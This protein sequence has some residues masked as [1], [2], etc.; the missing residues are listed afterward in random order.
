VYVR[1]ILIRHAD[2][3]ER[4]PSRWP[5]DTQ[6]PITEK[7][8]RRHRQVAKRLKRRGLVPTLL[9]TSPWLR[10]WQTAEITAHYTGGTAPLAAAA[11]AASPSLDQLEQAVGRPAPDAVVALVGHEPWLGELASLLLAGE[12]HRMG[13]DLPKS[14]VLGVECESLSPGSAVLQFLWRPKSE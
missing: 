4:D 13:T 2:A 1:L 7:G 9:L 10:A 6:R 14:G 12:P 5:D 8:R 11:L 3:G